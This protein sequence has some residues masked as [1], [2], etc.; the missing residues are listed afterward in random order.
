MTFLWEYFNEE[1]LCIIRTCN[2]SLYAV[3]EYEKVQTSQTELH[4][5]LVRLDLFRRLT[6]R[7]KEQNADEHERGWGAEGEN[8]MVTAY[9]GVVCDGRRGPRDQYVCWGIWTTWVGGGQQPPAADW[10]AATLTPRPL[11][12]TLS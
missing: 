5:T 8:R 10:P 3:N 12:H 9:G 4:Y 1:R 7:T 2:L 6:A 11:P